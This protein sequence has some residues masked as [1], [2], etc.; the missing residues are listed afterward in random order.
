MK[1]KQNR[2]NIILDLIRS[3]IISNQEDLINHLND[4]GLK[5]TQATLSRDLKV[6]KITK[7]PLSD[8]NYKYVLPLHIKNLNENTPEQS[9]VFH[10][11]ISSIEFSQ[12]LAVIKTKPGYAN[13]IAWDIDAYPNNVI[14]G[15][16][17]GDDTILVVLRQG[18]AHNIIYDTIKTILTTE[19]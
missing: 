17:A 18:V 1:N 9:A 15:T 14:L 16:I 7:Q 3:K 10:S 2:Y 11:A 6:L 12:N 13:A 19:K 5:V 8:G 4:C